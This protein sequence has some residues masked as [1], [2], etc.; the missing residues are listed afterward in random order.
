MAYTATRRATLAAL[1]ATPLLPLPLKA[2][3]PFPDRAIRL[4]VPFA[5]GGNSDLT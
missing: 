3:A 2:Q 5:P 1:A 4:I